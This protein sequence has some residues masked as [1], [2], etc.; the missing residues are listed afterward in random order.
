LALND[1]N[2][3]EIVDTLRMATSHD[4]AVVDL[5]D[6]QAWWET[7]LLVLCSGATRLGRPVAI[8]FVATEAGVEQSFQGWARPSELLRHLIEARDDLRL[9]YEQAAATAKQWELA[10][11]PPPT[12]PP[13]STSPLVL[14][15]SDPPVP[16][17]GFAVSD[18]GGRQHL[19]EF[20]PEQILAEEVGK[21]EQPSEPKGINVVRLRE[22]FAPYLRTVA[23]AESAE[24]RVWVAA[25][26]GTTEPFLAVTGQGGRYL[27]LVPR[28][29]AVNDILTALTSPTE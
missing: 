17:P 15:W 6:G 29:L 4:V 27:G 7:R 26:L 9:S 1:S 2:T 3:A 22:L 24:N 21:L 12:S 5:E 13:T 20:A 16:A 18:R 11:P 19:N 23:V 25:V 10:P 14:P 28:D 8:V